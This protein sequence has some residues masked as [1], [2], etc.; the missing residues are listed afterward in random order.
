MAVFN[1]L[2][3]SF[4][5][6][7]RP[8]NVYIT[9]HNKEDD[10]FIFI[11]NIQDLLCIHSWTEGTGFFP[12]CRQSCTIL[13][14]FPVLPVNFSRKN[15]AMKNKAPAWLHFVLVASLLVVAGCYPLSTGSKQWR[16]N[17]DE[18]MWAGKRAYLA[19]TPEKLNPDR[20][21]I[22][23]IVCDDLGKYEVSTYG[24]KNLQTPNIDQLGAEGVVFESGYVTSPTCAPS[25]AGIMTGRVQNR[26]GFETQANEVYPKNRFTYAMG[27]KM[28]SKG[29][30]NITTPPKY[31]RNPQILRQGLPPS[32]INLAEALQPLGYHTGIVGKWHMGRAPELIPAS[33]GFDYHYGFLGASTWYTPEREWPGV[34]NH[35]QDI[36]SAKYQWK[37]GRKGSGGIAEQGKEV[38]EEDYLTFAIK[39]KAIDY[40][41]EHKQE[42]FFLLCAF[43]APHVP[44]QAPEE[45]VERFSH[46][47]DENKR[48]YYAMIAALDDAVGELNQAVKDLGIEENTLIYFISDNGGATYT[49]A[50]DNGP[51]KGGKFTH[52]EGGISVPF[53]MKWKGQV[54]P[55]Q[56]YRHPVS[57]TDIF[58][59]SLL[60]AK[61]TLPPDRAYDGVDLLPFLRMS[62]SSS[63]QEADAVPHPQLFWRA[64]HI[65]AMRA[66]P[67]KFVLSMRDGWAELYDL[68]QDRSEEIN[69]KEKMPGL[70]EQLYQQHQRW[71][72]EELPEQ[73]LWPRL[74][75]Y[76]FLLKGKTYFFPS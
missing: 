22:L 13:C 32:E 65:W 48:V 6:V 29:E 1:F 31:P 27:K 38:R 7:P 23:L 35:E 64:D 9:L 68:S 14:S 42:P 8:K 47:E 17:W 39:D 51:L 74:V 67:Y 40:M 71:Q 45:Y 58:T 70:F 66:G 20:P 52:F 12:S 10:V 18:Q 75:D 37:K 50:T 72:E 56:R 76:R 30:F 3:S 69:L 11:Y 54:D 43:N 57:G 60:Q 59:T 24:G 55:G 16:V 2:Q 44:F 19:Q 33:R 41:R 46:I 28:V 5:P 21:N 73:Y 49:G 26:C 15:F 25:R 61:G 36:Y 4:A 62:K 53:M 34:V 63:K